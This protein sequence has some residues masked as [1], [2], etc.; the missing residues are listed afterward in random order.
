M[1]TW[2]SGGIGYIFD[3]SSSA[4][5][6][7]ALQHAGH[8]AD[9]DA[10]RVHLAEDAEL[11]HGLDGGRQ[12]AG[13]GLQAIAVDPAQDVLG[14]RELGLL[15]AR[16][17]AIAAGAHASS[18]A[19]IT[20]IVERI[21][22]PPFGLSPPSWLGRRGTTRGHFVALA[23]CSAVGTF[24]LTLRCGKTLRRRITMKTSR[25]CHAS[26]RAILF[27]A[28]AAGAGLLAASAGASAQVSTAARCA[29]AGR[30]RGAAG[31]E[32]QGRHLHS[33]RRLP[34][35]A[36]ARAAGC[37]AGITGRGSTAGPT[38]ARRGAS[39]TATAL[40]AIAPARSPATGTA[41]GTATAA[42]AGSAERQA[43]CRLGCP[44]DVH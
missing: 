29:P 24:R 2:S 8:E 44:F 5:L 34:V 26:G 37:T 7:L 14:R 21:T 4:R 27:A 39:S 12:L 18:R 20:A 33:G 19:S 35:R 42:C 3:T 30:R 28:L 16:R 10:G 31:R 32:P 1:A 15:L 17:G 38:T 25:Q 6:G 11:A 23:A 40:T 13:L 9:V 43:A 41:H 22:L 36:A